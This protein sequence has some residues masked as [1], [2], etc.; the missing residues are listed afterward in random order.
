[1]R[2][3][4]LMR[5]PIYF[6]L[7]SISNLSKCFLF[8]LLFPFFLEKRE[9]NLGKSCS[10]ITITALKKQRHRFQVNVRGVS[11]LSKSNQHVDLRMKLMRICCAI[12]VLAIL[13]QRTQSSTRGLFDADSCSCYATK[14]R[15]WL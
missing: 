4:T 3:F 11:D 9:E 14:P 10:T 1:M 2:I 6:T 15:Q 5:I 8:F 12:S 13:Q 7:C